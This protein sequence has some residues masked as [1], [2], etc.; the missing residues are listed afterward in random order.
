[1]AIATHL[2]KIKG[3]FDKNIWGYG[4]KE[5][6]KTLEEYVKKKINEIDGYYHA[7]LELFKIDDN[8]I[9][10][11][12]FIEAILSSVSKDIIEKW[13]KNHINEEGIMVTYIEIEE[14]MNPFSPE[15]NFLILIP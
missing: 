11:W 2:I 14:K 5:L 3:T 4:G 15:N 13:I 1:M 12:I 6:N 8:N 10:V 9:D 7:N